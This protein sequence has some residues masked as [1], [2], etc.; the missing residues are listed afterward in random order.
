M[1]GAYL[2]EARRGDD[3]GAVVEA[4]GVMALGLYGVAGALSRERVRA[5]S[6]RL[7]RSAHRRS[8]ARVSAFD[9]GAAICPVAVAVIINAPRQLFLATTAVNVR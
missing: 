5:R 8:I 9:G 7:R 4:P 3:K 1:G 6:R 2:V